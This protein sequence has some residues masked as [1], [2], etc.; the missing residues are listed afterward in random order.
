[1]NDQLLTFFHNHLGLFAATAGVLLLLIANEVHGSL[2][3]G[4]KLG[5]Q[6]A[7]RLI[8]DRSPI[9]VDLRSPADFK[10]SH[11][12]NAINLPLA[13]LEARAGE[14]GKDKSR[15]V[16]VY[17]ALG[18]GGDAVVTLKKLGFTEVY[19]LR[20]GINGWLSGNLPVTAR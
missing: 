2:T 1:M 15:P 19:P 8:N 14:I 3:G 4:K 17:D 11:L 13:K 20:G 16:L 5:P 18:G 6:E 10:K 7:V 12:L 9:V